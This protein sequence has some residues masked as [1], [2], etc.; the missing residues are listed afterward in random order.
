MKMKVSLILTIILVF[1]TNLL[2]QI[3]QRKGKNPVI[4]IPGIMGSKLVNQKTGEVVWVKL[5][6]AKMMICAFRFRLIYWL[7]GM[8]W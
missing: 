1:S 3:E 6:E 5:S 2:A 8:I 4:V 7:I